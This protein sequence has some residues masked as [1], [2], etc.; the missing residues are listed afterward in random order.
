MLN[1]N[2]VHKLPGLTKRKIPREGAIIA[3]LDVGAAKTVCIIARITPFGDG[4]LDCDIIG[5]GHFG[6]TLSEDDQNHLHHQ[7]PDYRVPQSFAQRE[8]AI[9]SAIEAAEAMAGERITDVHMCVPSHSIACARVGVDLDIGGGFVTSDDILDSLVEGSALTT[10]DGCEALH[11]VPIAYAIDGEMVGTDPRGLR[12]NRLTTYILGINAQANSLATLSAAVESAGLKVSSFIAAPLATSE[13]VL[14]DDEKELG[15]L[16]IDIGAHA[17]G[18]A[19]YTD[20]RMAGCGGCLPGAGFVTRDI[21]EAFST[22]LTHAERQKILHGTV[23][24]SAGDDH[25]FVDMVGFTDTDPRMRVSR[26]DMTQIILPRMEELYEALT[27]KL[28]GD[29]LDLSALRRV[30]ISGGGSQ[31]HGLCEHA[32]KVF[33]MK[34]RVA[35]PVGLDGH[36]EALTGPAFASAIGVLH[37]LSRLWGPETLF[38]EITKSE[39]EGT[40]QRSRAHTGNGRRRLRF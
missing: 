9:R 35:K 26:A 33:S 40:A 27:R 21:A 39:G 38:A 32:E 18:Y 8:Q 24:T 5:A 3:S 19:L 10:P 2:R 13:A 29:G 23:L 7:R 25:R 15:V 28:V 20:G 1:R 11:T 6:A 12:G 34:A 17:V 30:V 31:L 16:A 14:V 36:P 37:F 4:T 22:P